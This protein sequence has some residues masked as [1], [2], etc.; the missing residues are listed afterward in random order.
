[1]CILLIQGIIRGS[2]R[3]R[4]LNIGIVLILAGSAAF[5]LRRCQMF[6]QIRAARQ[7]LSEGHPALAVAILRKAESRGPE[8]PETL[9]LLGRA[10]RR[11]GALKEALSYLD[12]AAAAAW[13]EDEIRLQRQLLAAQT[14]AFASAG[15]FM[16]EVLARNVSDDIAEEIY[17]ARARG[18]YSSF[19]LGDALLCLEYWLKWR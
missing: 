11:T 5:G 17:E 16:E 7:A 18:Y 9:F 12:K 14:G 13:P 3:R 2:T 15:D 1:M 4:W 19:R 6:W 8:R 10:L